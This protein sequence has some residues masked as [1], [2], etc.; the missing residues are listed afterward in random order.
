MSRPALR[1]W[2][3]SVR[4]SDR[5]L[6][7]M[8]TPGLRHL[9]VA[10]AAVAAVMTAGCS[11]TY[12]V[13]D[14]DREVGSILDDGIDRTLG[15]RRQR[16]LYPDKLPPPEAAPPIE[17]PGI[18]PPG[19]DEIKAP[20]DTAQ[21]APARGEAAGQESETG[22]A[23]DP[24]V[25]SAGDG[26]GELPDRVLRRAAGVPEAAVQA[27]ETYDLERALRT[28][29]QHNR[30]YLTQR[31][32]LYSAGL[33][34]SLARFNFGPQF[35]SA[36]RT[37]VSDAE[38]GVAQSEVAASLGVSQILPT[39]GTLAL[40][41]SANAVWPYGSQGL[42]DN[43]GSSVSASLRQ[44]LLRGAGYIP[45]HEPLT[46]AERSFVYSIRDFQLFRENFSIQI[47]RTYFNLVSQRQSLTIE[48]ANYQG[49]V[50]DRRKSEALYQMDRNTE[51]EVFRARRRE[52]TAKDQL[53]SARAAYDRAVDEF[54]ILLGLP[55]TDAIVI[56]DAEPP[57]EPVRLEL[58]SAVA[59]ARHN[60]LDIITQ[61]Q[62]VEDAER[63]LTIAANALLPDLDFTASYG[64]TGGGTGEDQFGPDTWN[65]SIGLE[66]EVPLQ[67]KPER[68]S[69]RLTQIRLEQS[70]RALSLRYDQLALDI[71]DA[72]RQLRTIEERIV[73]QEGQIEQERAAVTV[74]E[75]RYESGSL[76]N[77]DLLEARQALVNNKNALIRLKVD[78]F[79]ARLSLLRDMG[80]FFIDDQGMWQ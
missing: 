59:A 74:T 2:E 23:V 42:L 24:P 49:A 46:Q 67:R 8:P 6:P 37:L 20:D 61:R 72:L 62:Q 12:W 53:I 34:L 25:E 60:R 58:D 19:A 9:S 10:I 17:Q 69:Y 54:K 43:Y 30:Q 5:A 47:A 48:D 31:E 3:S 36:I 15:D 63:Q 65:S 1:P 7:L 68:N 18:R 21:Q 71:R 28:A 29:V 73:L 76:D 77:R 41:S 66:F 57:F 35:N 75:I 78:H 22:E 40:T 16:A 52:I 13:D 70:K 14:A 38:D 4:A 27:A 39:G 45:S 44:P 32:Q 51:A 64:L 33:S 56:A 11:T 26:S 80:L 79:I 55:T 50:F